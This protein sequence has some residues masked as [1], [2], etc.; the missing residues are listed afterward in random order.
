MFLPNGEVIQMPKQRSTVGPIYDLSREQALH[1]QMQVSM[2]MRCEASSNPWYVGQACYDCVQRRALSSRMQNTMLQQ[3]AGAWAKIPPI[4]HA[5][6]HLG[7]EVGPDTE[8]QG[9]HLLMVLQALQANND[10]YP[11]HGIEVCYRCASCCAAYVL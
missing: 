1:V 5:G 6:T 9:V 7:M 10:P 4:Q 11:D 8:G 3:E 2:C